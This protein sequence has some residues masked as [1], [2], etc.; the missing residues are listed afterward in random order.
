M[1][2]NN[3][4]VM[5]IVNATPDSFYANSRTAQCGAAVDLARKHVAEGADLIDIGGQSTR[6]GARAI[7]ATEERARIL[8][9]VEAVA[10]LP[11]DFK[12]SIDTFYAEVAAAA[13]DAGA[14]RVNDVSAGR[15]D[16]ALLDLVRERQTPYILMHAADPLDAGKAPRYNDVAAD[17]RNFLAERLDALSGCDVWVDPGFGFGKTAA[18]NFELL[19]NL[20]CIV[21]LGAPVL[22][23]L[24]RKRLIYE[25]LGCSPEDAL[26]GTTFLHAIALSHGA[27]ILRVHDV[28]PAVECLA[29]HTTMHTF[30]TL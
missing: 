24:S 22:V 11:G 5:G 23:G 18:T 14:H 20:S 10:A 8:P 17:V 1:N 3:F 19:R 6:P 7:S 15:R 4:K 21:E 27:R 30:A 25:T 12:I 2:L 13:L 9:V 16:P 28:A 29:L 26:G